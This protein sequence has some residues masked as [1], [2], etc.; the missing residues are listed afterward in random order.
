[1]APAPQPW[2]S[3][4]TTRYRLSATHLSTNTASTGTMFGTYIPVYRYHQYVTSLVLSCRH[5][6]ESTGLEPQISVLRLEE[7][8]RVRVGRGRRDDRHPGTP[9]P[10][11]QVNSQI[12]DRAL[13]CEGLVVV[14]CVSK[15]L[16]SAQGSSSGP[17]SGLQCGTF[18]QNVARF[19]GRRRFPHNIQRT[20]VAEPEPLQR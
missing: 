13:I 17:R 1:M 12:H 9:G 10:E 20:G 15:V 14:K 2:N 8:L 16:R 5:S 19:R 7:D 11:H 18:R 4:L 6:W 3:I